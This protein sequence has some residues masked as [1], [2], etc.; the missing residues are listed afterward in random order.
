MDVRSKDSGLVTAPG[1]EPLTL[2]CRCPPLA[3]RPAQKVNKCCSQGGASSKG[4][5][6]LKRRPLGGR[7]PDA[8]AVAN[9]AGIH[10]IAACDST[11]STATTLLPLCGAFRHLTNDKA[12]CG[13]ETTE[14]GNFPLL[15]LVE[16]QQAQNN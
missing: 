8:A 6:G 5:A 3:P 1:E 7:E 16:R 10:Y 2:A 4:H 11:V 9:S 15:L 14:A 13:K 12:T